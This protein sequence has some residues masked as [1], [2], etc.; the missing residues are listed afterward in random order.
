MF[1]VFYADRSQGH[2]QLSSSITFSKSEYH[3]PRHSSQVA[4]LSTRN[5]FV[6]M[7][8]SF[9]YSITSSPQPKLAFTNRVYISKNNF[10]ALGSAARSMGVHISA[11]DPS[12]NITVGSCVFLAR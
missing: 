6:A 11:A 12:V 5:P 4:Q 1:Y 3:L 9:E 10:N 2:K 7:S 8:K